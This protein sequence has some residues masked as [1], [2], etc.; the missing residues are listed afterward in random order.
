MRER[1]FFSRDF[2]YIT[3]LKSKVIYVHVQLGTDM[4]T[5]Y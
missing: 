2:L 4:C 3:K 1:M 5:V